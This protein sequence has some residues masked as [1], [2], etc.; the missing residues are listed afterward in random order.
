M[1]KRRAR[2]RAAQRRAKAREVHAPYIVNPAYDWIFFLLPPSVALLLGLA[3]SNTWLTQGTLQLWQY[4][5]KPSHFLIQIFTY[6]HLVLV[7][8]RSHGNPNI[9]REFPLRFTLVPLLLWGAMLQWTWVFVS[10]LVL[11]VF[12]DVYH[13]SLQTFGFARLYDRQAGNDPQVGRRLDWWLNLL[14]YAGPMVGGA[15]MLGHFSVFEYY[16]WV[17]ADFFTRIPAQMESHQ[18]YFT[19]GLLGLG[20]AY[21]AFYVGAYARLRTQGYQVPFQKVFLLSTTGAC[22]LVCW[23]F[24]SFGEAFFVMNFFHAL[25]YFGLVWWSEKSHIQRAFRLPN[26]TWGKPAAFALFIAL[27][28]AYG[29]AAEMVPTEIV[30][31][32]ALILVISILHFWY[33]GFIWSVRKKQI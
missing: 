30:W 11:V 12:W 27:P 15:T 26:T 6:A 23:G 17:G 24:N 21:L 19:W 14:L 4:E 1:S 2:E 5:A 22:S 16:E 31:A 10:V 29:V 9:F 28:V 33:D 3:I 13:S 32:W 7:F 18:A 25:Q 20:S 8:F